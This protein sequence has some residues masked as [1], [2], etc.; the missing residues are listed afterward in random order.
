M[1]VWKNNTYKF[2][3][4]L[5]MEWYDDIRQCIAMYRFDDRINLK[6][7]EE[8]ASQSLNDEMQKTMQSL[9]FL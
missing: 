2:L 7:S 8:V 1:L 9:W 3:Q 4:I 6:R 5:D